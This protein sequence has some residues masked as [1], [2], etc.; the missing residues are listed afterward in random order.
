MTG[1]MAGYSKRPLVEKLGIRPGARVAI[2]GA[3]DGYEA[4]LGPLPEGVERS[5][6]PPLDFI[7][8]FAFDRAALERAFREM[9]PKLAHDGMLWAS[10]PKKAAKLPTDLDENVVR[11][12]G[13]DQGLVDVK[14]AAVDDVWS[15]LK[16]V[17]RLKDR[18]GV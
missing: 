14:V 13:L 2:A 4:A 18:P 8:V 9:K 7:H 16:F 12:I 3:P 11:R 6:D 17:Y 15:G 5:L 10:W 1:A